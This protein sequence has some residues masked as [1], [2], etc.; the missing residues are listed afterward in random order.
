MTNLPALHIWV[1]PTKGQCGIRQ[2]I[3]DDGE[4]RRVKDMERVLAKQ[5]ESG[6]YRI[7]V[8]DDPENPVRIVPPKEAGEL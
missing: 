6:L 4:L 2:V 7:V 5:G 3:R 1:D 8:M